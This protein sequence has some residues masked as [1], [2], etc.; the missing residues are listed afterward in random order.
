M[1]YGEYKEIMGVLI[2]KGQ[3][4]P[5]FPFPLRGLMHNMTRGFLLKG[6]GESEG[7]FRVGVGF[8]VGSVP[9]TSW[10]EH[11]LA[12]RLPVAFPYATCGF[13]V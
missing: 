5:C 7:W 8:R 13:S 1:I 11:I 3:V 10:C 4:E 9:T 12:K 6:L 2:R